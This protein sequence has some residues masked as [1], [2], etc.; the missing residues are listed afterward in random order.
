MEIGNVKEGNKLSISTISKKRAS[1]EDFA[2]ELGVQCG[3]TDLAVKAQDAIE[4]K[5]RVYGVYQQKQLV[6]IYI[7]EWVKDYFIDNRDNADA[8]SDLQKIFEDGRAAYRMVFQYLAEEV[9]QYQKEVEE[10][11]EGDLKSMVEWGTVSGIEWGE[12]LIYRKSMD[13]KDKDGM[14]TAAR[15]G[16]G[17]LCGWV[18]GWLRLDSIA[19]GLCFG[20]CYANIF[21]GIILSSSN[22]KQDWR[23][24]DFVNQKY[25]EDKEE[26]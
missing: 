16:L 17:F 2:S 4:H 23:T 3:Q 22:R 21:G 25:I 7:F 6:G 24:Y 5:G 26:V 18:I 9:T 11:I 20:V 19:F 8:I 10:K 12:N 1:K 14:N 13:K 15:Y